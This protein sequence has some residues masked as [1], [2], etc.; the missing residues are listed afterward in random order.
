MVKSMKKSLIKKIVTA[1]VFLAA[2]L[3]IDAVMNQKNTDVTM[4]MPAATLPVVSVQLGDYKVNTMY[5]YTSRQEEVYMKDTLTPVSSDRSISLVV[6]TFKT[7]VSTIAYEVRSIDGERLIEGGE[8]TDFRK[9]GE[10][11]GFSLQLKDLIEKD[12][13]YSFITILTMEDG[14]RS[15]YYARFIQ[16]EGYYEAEKLDYITWF[17]DTVYEGGDGE[18]LRKY[19]ESN[20]QGNNKT[21]HKVTINSSLKQVMWNQMKVEKVDEPVILIREITEQTM[22]ACLQYTVK[23]GSGKTTDYYHVE[24]YFRIR[25]TPGRV[26]LLDYERTMDEYFAA[27][28]R[29]FANDRIQMGI[30][31]EDFPLEETEGG[32]ILAFVSSNR[33]FLYNTVENKLAQ[34]FSFYD[35]SN[36]DIRT[37]NRE[38]SIK[39]LKMEDG[40]NLTFM[41]SGYMNRGIHEG[42]VGIAI[43]YYNSVSNL[44]EE[45][46][47][48]PYTKAAGIL[49]K[50]VENISYFNMN[51]HVFLLLGGNLYDIALDTKTYEIIA[52]GLVE[53]TFKVSDSGRSI[54]WLKENEP[55]AS[56]V[57]IWRNLSNGEQQ[58]IRAGINEYI[59]PLGFMGEDLV[60]GLV[61]KSDMT[62][63]RIGNT[64]FPAYK[65]IIRNSDGHNV[66]VY[67]KADIYVI[68]CVIEDN[69]ITLN[70]VE[71]SEEGKYNA[72]QNDQIASND[73]GESRVNQINTVAVEIYETI[74][75][76]LLKNRVEAGTLKVLTPREVIFEGGREIV[77][78]S[79]SEILQH[80]VYGPYGVE[81]VCSSPAEAVSY[82][83]EAAGSVMDSRGNY[84]WKKG[85]YFTRNQIMAIEG[86]KADDEK[87]A[88]AVCLDT[89]LQ[90]EG[91]S[92]LTQPMLER[93]EDAFSI[94]E[95]NLR[96][97]DIL[98]LS[99]CSLD[100]VL[101]YPDRDIPVLAI[102]EEGKTVLII[103]FNEQNVVLMD[104]STG[105]VYKKGMNDSRTMFEE[106]G[107]RF[108]TY[109][110]REE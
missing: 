35:K 8:I 20:A 34:I 92:R 43:Y 105:T 55:Y 90:Y 62:I 74:V 50:E 58:E 79:E 66:K 83:Y 27:E 10:Q 44:V 96:D 16:Q 6:D 13:E 5:G 51:S 48:I 2:L 24:E 15:Y 97:A 47:F 25:Y 76:I 77:L 33:L 52:S 99:G 64:L 65:V 3:V 85:R 102:L 91:I 82:A 49:M 100:S 37:S 98:D 26:Y 60:F 39:I 41:V 68:G 93:G 1:V 11:I 110:R 56:T 72:I 53:D 59:T 103:G 40:G 23:T 31:A 95:S 75:Q 63:D 29:S 61:R 78:E 84:I 42:K 108:I 71:K 109:V 104:P 94:L 80:Y 38:F 73:V 67:E 81:H 22:G 86:E 45:Q 87:S 4:E 21:F 19:L 106:G 32:K 28:G 7:Q 54:V 9:Q 70:R 12:K 46:I 36:F 18:E 14:S 101:Y 89:I 88:L 107:N 30:T 17:H 57:L 69:Q